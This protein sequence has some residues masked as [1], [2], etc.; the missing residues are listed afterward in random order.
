RINSVLFYS[1]LYCGINFFNGVYS[2]F[3][4]IYSPNLAKKSVRVYL[5]FILLVFFI[6]WRINAETNHVNFNYIYVLFLFA[7]IPLLTSL[8]RLLLILVRKKWRNINRERRYKLVVIGDT[9]LAEEIYFQLATNV[10]I[11]YK[12]VGFY[13]NKAPTEK[14]LAKYWLGKIDDVKQYDALNDVHYIICSLKAYERSPKLQQ[15]FKEADNYMAKIKFVVTDFIYS[16]QMLTFDCN[17]QIPVFT[18]RKEPLED[19]KNF[20]IKG[21]LDIFI[22]LLVLLFILSWL[23]PLVGL[24]IK[25]E[26]KGPVFFRQRRTGYNNKEFTCL[27][28]RS[29]CVNKDADKLQATKHDVRITRVGRFLR[30]TNLDEMPQFINVFK[31]EMSIVG[32]RPHMVAQTHYYA[33]EIDKYM[34]RQYVLPGI[35]GWAQVMGCRGETKR[36]EDMAMR[37]RYDIWYLENW[38]FWLD[39]KIVILTILHEIKGD[40]N[41]Y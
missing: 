33:N 30:K 41:A 5:I 20:V 29:M 34:V 36:K 37:V 28:F 14:K 24:L 32:P 16:N 21:I 8:S 4:K 39:V 22:A 19:T 11:D 13:S 15:L 9:K 2:T 27:K 17:H 25:L 31:G 1:I 12:L 10:L 6:F 3:Y 38:T 7:Y 23:I 18:T 35:T 26:S 40:P